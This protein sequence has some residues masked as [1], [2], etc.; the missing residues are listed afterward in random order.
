MSCLIFVQYFNFQL[1]PE[2][3]Y[4][5]WLWEI[6][7]GPKKQLEDMDPNTKEYWRRVR[8]AGLNQ[9]NRLEETKRRH[10]Y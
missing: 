2:S 7:I 4:P 3:E 8:K 5:D 10:L 9:N 1:K 6:H